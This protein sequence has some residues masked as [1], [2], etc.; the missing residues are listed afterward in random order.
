MIVVDNEKLLSVVQSTDKTLTLDGA[1]R[2]TDEIPVSDLAFVGLD[3]VKKVE[4][5]EFQLWVAGD[6]A[7]GKPVSFEVK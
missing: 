1:F 4:P 2:L 7:S 6:S 3:G 5:G